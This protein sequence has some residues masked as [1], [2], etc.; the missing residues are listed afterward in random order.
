MWDWLQNHPAKTIGWSSCDCGAPFVPGA[1]LDPFAGT[2][3]TLV[4][5][6]RLGRRYT[7][8]ELS[9]RYC[10]MAA[11]KLAVWWKDA[12]IREPVA[13]QGMLL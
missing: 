6:R 11:K 8:V 9:E 5:A 4:A 13:A 1:V 3:T 2:G 10:E 12:A 7:G